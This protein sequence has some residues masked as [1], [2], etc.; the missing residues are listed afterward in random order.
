[1]IAPCYNLVV[2]AMPII[3]EEEARVL[4]TPYL[5]RLEGLYRKAWDMWLTNPVAARMQNT[6]VRANIIFNDALS[7]AKA[8]FDGSGPARYF[9]R[10]KWKGLLFN[11]QLFM[12]LK[13]GSG[14]LKSSN[15]RT[16]A[17][18]AFHDQ[19]QDL[20]DGIA[21]CELLYVLSDDETEIERVAIVHR[22]KKSVVWAIDAAGG[23]EAQQVI[24]FA[25]MLAGDGGGSVANRVVK[26]KRIG[27][28]ENGTQ[29]KSASGGGLST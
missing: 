25:P 17:A 10:G 7:Q 24:P 27:E 22:H 4:V 13:K 11:D 21:R 9:E 1:M 5:P 15:V 20:F 2:V 26:P 23:E 18:V 3:A 14:E 28:D 6:T 29:R 16:K 19:N 8:E 12:R